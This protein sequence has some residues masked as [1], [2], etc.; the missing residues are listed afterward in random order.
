[1][2]FK[3][4]KKKVI[5]DYITSQLKKLIVKQEIKIGDKLPNE[6]E[7]C[8]LF[9]ASRSSIREALRTLESQGLLRRTN[10]GTFVQADLSGI[11]EESFILQILLNNWS[12][13]D[14]QATRVMLERELIRLAT[15]KHTEENLLKMS[16]HIN[17]ME[18]SLKNKDN[19]VFVESDIAFHNE[20]ALAGG[21]QVM[22]L[23]YNSISDLIFKVQKTVVYDEEVK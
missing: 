3:P 9:D 17:Q 12:L 5:S 21:N 15:I 18:S 7:L 8:N 22:Q 13:E 23:L 6:R 11:I 20:I 19:N 1:M 10:A 4:I 16:Q 2:E 14:I